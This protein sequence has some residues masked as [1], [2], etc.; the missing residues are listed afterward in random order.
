MSVAHPSRSDR[1][2]SAQRGQCGV[3]GAAPWT[4]S[5]LDLL[6]PWKLHFRHP[7]MNNRETI[8]KRGRGGIFEKKQI[9]AYKKVQYTLCFRMVIFSSEARIFL[10]FNLLF[11][12]YP[13]PT[14]ALNYISGWKLSSLF[15]FLP[16][17]CS[18]TIMMSGCYVN[19]SLVF[20][21]L[22]WN[23]FHTLIMSVCDVNL[24]LVKIFIVEKKCFRSLS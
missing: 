1:L 16:W 14:H 5:I 23:W 20:S 3:R 19:L 9:E 6:A 22:P 17:N 13:N 4:F 12:K 8:K 18:H 15:L 7:N 11:L 21:F 2:D 24:S 10:N